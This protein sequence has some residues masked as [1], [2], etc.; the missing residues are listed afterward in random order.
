MAS[1]KGVTSTFL[2]GTEGMRSML[3]EEGIE[4]YS[5]QPEFVVLG[6]DTEI[7]YEKL[8]TVNTSS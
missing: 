4:T 7:S 3:E 2:V 8:A 5:E 1:K 6:Y